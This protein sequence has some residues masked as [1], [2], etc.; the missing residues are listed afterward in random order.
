MESVRKNKNE[1]LLGSSSP[2]SRPEEKFGLMGLLVVSV[3]I[4]GTRVSWSSSLGVSSGE[5][6]FAPSCA[7]P[8][9]TL[10][11]VLLSGGVIAFVLRG[12]LECDRGVVLRWK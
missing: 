10:S 3:G 1:L 2:S 12:E 5:A 11:I 4:G 9:S 6:S 8:R 7:F